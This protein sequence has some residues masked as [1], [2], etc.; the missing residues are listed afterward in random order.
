MGRQ[1]D[2]YKRTEGGERRKDR[3]CEREELGLGKIGRRERSRGN[4]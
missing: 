4:W 1:T 2:R 3:E